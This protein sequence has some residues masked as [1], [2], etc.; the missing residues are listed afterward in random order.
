MAERKLRSRSYP[1]VAL[2]EAVELLRRFPLDPS[3]P[4]RQGE[5]ISIAW[6]H[7][8]ANSGLALRKL[9]ALGQFGLLIGRE[10][11]FSPTDLGN[12]LL[13][14]DCDSAVF[15]TLLREACRN[16]PFFQDV[17]QRYDSV[18]R[19]PVL[20]GAALAR[21]H[22]SQE[23]VQEEVA[24]LLMSSARHA[25]ILDEYGVFT[26]EYY[27]ETH[28]PRPSPAPGAPLSRQGASSEG[29]DTET[30][31]RDLQK[32]SFLLTEGKSAEL[33]VQGQLNESDISILRA[34]VDVLELQARLNRPG[35]TVHM[36]LVRG[37][38]KS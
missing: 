8:S 33:Q 18:G 30:E 15:A 23:S 4:W 1:A 6:G 27:D 29:R 34:Q 14:I 3:S 5:A 35:R 10:G 36:D 20:L 24:A 17:F 13:R 32:F 37:E 28:Q 19:V 2:P 38:R 25:G 31:P 16:P 22:G 21:E 12:R 7:A 9:S 26:D 11:L